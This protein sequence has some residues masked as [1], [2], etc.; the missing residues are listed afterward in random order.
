MM[1]H[2]IWRVQ[3]FEIVAPFT[4]HLR[5]TDGA[6]QRVDFSPILVGELFGLLRDLLLFNQV[7]L[8]PE[9][10]TVVWPNSADFNPATLF[11]W[12]EHEM[13][14]RALAQRWEHATA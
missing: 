12:P 14:F 4:L 10:H 3:S 6:E 13:A 11:D 1:T 9:V 8:D 7:R 2:R 5:V